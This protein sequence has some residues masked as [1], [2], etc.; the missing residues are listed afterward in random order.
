MFGKFGHLKD[1]SQSCLTS[2]VRK[3]SVKK[4][5]E[6]V[7]LQLIKNKIDNMIFSR[8]AQDIGNVTS[9]RLT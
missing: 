4:P 1:D 2:R 7:N 8:Y 3:E 9:W 5:Q 6:S